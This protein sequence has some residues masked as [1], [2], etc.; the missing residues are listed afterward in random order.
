MIQPCWEYGG[1]EVAHT[2][3]PTGDRTKG[4]AVP[5]AREKLEPASQDQAAESITADSTVGSGSL[6]FGKIHK[7]VRA[8]N[9]STT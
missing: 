8:A 4:T 9:N 6:L 2:L 3:V 5:D 1:A 7:K